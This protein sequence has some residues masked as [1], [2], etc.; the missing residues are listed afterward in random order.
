MHIDDNIDYDLVTK[1][2]MVGLV[3]VVF[4]KVKVTSVM[5]ER[6]KTGF[7]GNFANKGAVVARLKVDKISI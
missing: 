3:L 7:G 6:I 4:S 2:A 1:I 5:T